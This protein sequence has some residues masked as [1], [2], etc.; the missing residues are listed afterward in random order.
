MGFSQY[1][2]FDYKE[3]ELVEL[4]MNL[5]FKKEDKLFIYRNEDVLFEVAIEN[6]GLYSHRSGNYFE[7]LGK[8]VESIGD[9]STS[10]T[11][12]DYP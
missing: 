8:L 1:L 11:I 4:L 6:Y 12:E 5:D 9:I 3:K 7:I 10:L 2:R